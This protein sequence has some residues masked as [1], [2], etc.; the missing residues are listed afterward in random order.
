MPTAS[1]RVWPEWLRQYEREN[2]ER[3][4][5][6]KV[7]WALVGYS[8][9]F[10]MLFQSGHLLVRSAIRLSARIH[11]SCCKLSTSL[12]EVSIFGAAVHASVNL[13]LSLLLPLA[14]AGV[15]LTSLFALSA[16]AILRFS[17]PCKIT[18]SVMSSKSDDR[19]PLSYYS[20]AGQG[21]WAWTKVNGSQRRRVKP[22][23]VK[24]RNNWPKVSVRWAFCTQRLEVK[25]DNSATP[26]TASKE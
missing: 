18:D 10:S 14:C 12:L 8:F 26:D 6:S 1:R 19:L 23:D 24:L 13:L 3:A 16:N 25:D 2:C 15:K 11:S 5:V 4:K 17:D 21:D 22:K 20:Q 7:K 9:C